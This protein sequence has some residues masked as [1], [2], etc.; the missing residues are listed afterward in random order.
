MDVRDKLYYGEQ[1]E[2]GVDISLLRWML[3]HSP[4]ERLL[5]M[6]R[7]ARDTELLLEYGRRN[8]EA[9]APANR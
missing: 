5:I 1:D 4:L 7:H 3:S 8:R 9:Q 2:N 6:E